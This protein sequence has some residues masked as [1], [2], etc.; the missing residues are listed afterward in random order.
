VLLQDIQ[1]LL[2]AHPEADIT[3]VRRWV[4]EFATAMSTPDM[5]DEFD[6]LAAGSKS[7]S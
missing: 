2:A 1:G 3:T 5:L 7:K 6:K 4:S